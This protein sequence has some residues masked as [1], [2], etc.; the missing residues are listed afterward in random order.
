MDKTHQEPIQH[1][2]A[3]DGKKVQNS[4]L[5]NKEQKGEKNNL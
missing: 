4:Q 3:H 5:L 2:Q 1:K